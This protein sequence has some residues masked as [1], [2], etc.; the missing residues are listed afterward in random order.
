[1]AQY[2]VFTDEAQTL[3]GDKTLSGSTSLSGKVGFYG[4]APIAIRATNSQH[5]TSN[6]AAY[7][8]TSCSALLGA[9]AQEVTNTLLGLG[10]WTSP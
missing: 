8:N 5:V 4:T 3:T 1:M 9:W 6:V 10:I 2:P 7:T